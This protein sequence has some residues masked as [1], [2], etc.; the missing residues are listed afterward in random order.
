MDEK[1]EGNQ[2]QTRNKFRVP[3]E[4]L[5]ESHCGHGKVRQEERGHEKYS[6]RGM[7]GSESARH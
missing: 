3:E 4:E 2:P 1:W 6:L 7:Q 5:I